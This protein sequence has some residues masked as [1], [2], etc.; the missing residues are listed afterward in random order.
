MTFPWPVF[1]ALGSTG[2]NARDEKK[3]EDNSGIKSVP[4]HSRSLNSMSLTWHCFPRIANLIR[5]F[6][7]LLKTTLVRLPLF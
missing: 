1:A 3:R 2:I 6:V 7:F 4:H 5:V